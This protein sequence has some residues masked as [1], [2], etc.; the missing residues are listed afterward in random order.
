MGAEL[1]HVLI[2]ED[3]HLMRGGLVALLS[4]E[5]DIAV[6]AELDSG[7]KIISA[8]LE[9]SPDVALIDIR[10]RGG[11]AAAIA[12]HKQVPECGT[13][14]MAEHRRPRDLRRGMNAHILGFVLTDVRPATLADA[15]RRVARGERVVDSELAFATLETAQNPLTSREL[16]VLE[17]AAQGASPDEIAEQLYLSVRTVRNHLSRII[18]KTSA[19]NRVDAIRIA[20]EA[21][22]L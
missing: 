7:E 2:A 10:V 13:I 15:V 14:I 12:L 9:L 8:A 1:I 22:W 5:T 11:F 20:G 3:L 19:R 6:V 21:G 18:S 17:A 16:E 4:A